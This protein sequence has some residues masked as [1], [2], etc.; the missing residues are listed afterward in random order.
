MI[1]PPARV[2][3]YWAMVQE[4]EAIRLRKEAGLPPSWTEDAILRDYKFTNV[5]RIHDRTTREL[6]ELYT[7]NKGADPRLI[8]LNCAIARYFGTSEFM[9]V[10]GWQTGFRPAQIKALA[11]CRM[12]AGERVFTGAYLITS[13][14]IKGPKAPVIVDTFLADLWRQSKEIAALLP[15]VNWQQFH[16]RLMK[17][18]GFGGTG[19]L[20]K[21]VSLDVR[22]FQD[23]QPADR[24]TWT[25]VG[26]GSKRGAA[27][28][29]GDDSGKGTLN[30]AQTLEVCRGLW[31]ARPE[32]FADF[33]L[34]DVQ[35]SLCEHSKYL[36][37]KLGQ[38]RP[39]SRYHAST[40]A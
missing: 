25:P 5:R 12:A 40:L 11:A 39:R 23:E 33:E 9:R 7:P 10:L 15:I 38:G 2:A 32:Q 14:G 8:L 24:Y 27:R 16:E 19:F 36:K 34:H 29:L 30:N 3:A 31:E 21:E 20:A 1:L 4:R 37:V 6:L 26:P 35:W 18:H 22:L 17:V 28:L 13:C